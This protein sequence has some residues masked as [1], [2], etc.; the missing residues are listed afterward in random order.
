MIDRAARR[1]TGSRAGRG[2]RTDDAPDAEIVRFPAR[3]RWARLD[4]NQG[5]TDYEIGF[6]APSCVLVR[7]ESGSSRGKVE[8]ACAE[9]AQEC[10]PVREIACRVLALLKDQ[11]RSWIDLG[12]MCS[13]CKPSAL[14]HERRTSVPCV[15]CFQ[16]WS[17]RRYR[18]AV[19][20]R[21]VRTRGFLEAWRTLPPAAPLQFSR[22][23]GRCFGVPQHLP[24]FGSSRPRSAYALPVRARDAVRRR[25][26]PYRGLGR[27]RR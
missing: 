15:V 27:S 13:A 11:E 14:C 17:A 7:P 10:I 12:L 2:S 21:S 6:V 18:P 25:R 9:D 19:L 16:I 1:S 4:S 3:S 20:S 22:S 23:R 26:R 5:P 8:S 24:G